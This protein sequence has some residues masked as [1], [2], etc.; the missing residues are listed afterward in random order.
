VAKAREKDLQGA[1][2]LEGLQLHQLLAHVLLNLVVVVLVV[3]FEPELEG[4]RQTLPD[5]LVAKL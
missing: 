3:V 5:V 2:N 1:G 4:A